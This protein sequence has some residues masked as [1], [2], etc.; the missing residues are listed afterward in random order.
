M[1][2]L[3][4]RVL[5]PV[6]CFVVSLAAGAN[7]ADRTDGA[8]IARAADCM[9][10]HTGPDGTEWAGGRFI[11]T[12]LGAIMAPNISS[13]DEYGIGRYTKEQFEAVLRDG[14]SPQHMLYPAM[15]YASYRGMSDE[16][17][18]A[19]YAYMMGV[20]PV[21]RAPE[22]ATDL[23]FPFNM[24]ILMRFW[25]AMALKDR[26]APVQADAQVERGAYLVDVLGHCGTC[27]TPRNGLMVSEPD[28]YLGGASIQGWRA[29]N[30]T[31]D[32]TGGLGNWGVADIAEYL[33][34]GQAMNVAQAAG[35]M[36]ETVHFSTRHMKDEDL[37]A[38]GAYLKTVSPLKTQGQ[39]RP[40]V[41]PGDKRP[42]D[43][44]DAGSIRANLAAALDR[45]DL[46]GAEKLY[47]TQCA[48]CHNVGGEGETAAYYP[49]LLDNGAVRREDATNLVMVIAHGVR[50]ET[51]YRA[52]PMPGFSDDL[53]ADQ[54]A[55]VA[56]YVRA[57]F[58][59]QEGSAL[60]GGDVQ[61][62]LAATPDLPWYMRYAGVLAWIAVAAALVILA[63]IAWFVW[64]H[65]GPNRTGRPA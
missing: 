19:L 63:A 28:R 50:H 21:D 54:I 25:N 24:R 49:P 7:A 32:T 20:E 59:G 12:P 52:P 16:D 13:S 9:S 26:E 61:T 51:L 65:L 35:P 8:Y 58:G 37:S 17:V 3:K 55:D 44:H 15:P 4:K 64:R 29:P 42:D 53:N 40:I 5:L 6:I 27:H 56:N 47:V 34:T 39:T 60:T 46:A 2:E 18:D 38:I 11:E 48:A 33:R 23:D 10:C 36:G 45:D 57:E 22:G 30:I 1:S 31:S 62:I 41:L 14:K 43:T